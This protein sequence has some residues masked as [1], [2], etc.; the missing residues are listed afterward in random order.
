MNKRV[1]EILLVVAILWGATS[2]YLYLQLKNNPKVVAVTSLNPLLPQ[3]NVQL[4]ELEKITFLRQFL[5]R[6]FNYDSNNFW[7]SQTSLSFLMSPELRDK[8]IEETRRLRE[9]IQQRNA[10]RKGQIISLSA[11]GNNFDALIGIEIK[12][13]Q[14]PKTDL[15]SVVQLSLGTTERTLEN[16][17]GLVVKKMDFVKSSSDTPSFN[18]TLKIK[19]KVPLAITLPCAIE[20]IESSSESALSTKITTLNVS[21]IQLSATNPLKETIH[22][23]AYC[24]DLEFVFDVAS[25]STNPDLF[26]AFPLSAGIVRK[27]EVP[28]INQAAPKKRQKDI[29]DKAIEKMMGVKFQD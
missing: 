13:G 26:K 17:W 20:N 25:T 18:S 2:T 21:E 12:E 28:V 9:K 16:P 8:H 27:K 10:A 4:N 3:E 14:E 15:N 19:E 7:Q 24:K 1:L 5:D 23:K 11:Q 29:Y 22:M 6:Y